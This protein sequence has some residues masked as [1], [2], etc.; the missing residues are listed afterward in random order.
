MFWTTLLSYEGPCSI[1][2]L[3]DEIL[4]FEFDAYPVTLTGASDLQLILGGVYMSVNR[5][6]I[7]S[8]KG[9]SPIGHQAII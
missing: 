2:H 6:S 7:G 8:D 3:A 5:F 4:H 9:L 1:R